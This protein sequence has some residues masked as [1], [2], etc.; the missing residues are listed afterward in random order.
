MLCFPK[1]DEALMMINRLVKPTFRVDMRHTEAKDHEL[2]LPILRM[3]QCL[4]G[5]KQIL[6][7]HSY[8]SIPFQNEIHD[9]AYAIIQRKVTL[10]AFV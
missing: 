9:N 7:W 10:S 2:T 4:M 1:V 3:P 8:S 5:L 6:P